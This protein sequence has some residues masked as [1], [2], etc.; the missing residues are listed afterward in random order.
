[1]STSILVGYATRYGSTQEVAEA[2]AATLR[3]DGTAVDCRPLKEVKTLEGYTARRGGGA[4]L[5]VPLAQGRQ[6]LPLA[7]SASPHSAA[8]GGL[9]DGAAE[10]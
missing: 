10:R 6:K 9:C 2:I 3:E 1:M 8:G 7:A 4:A 5:Y